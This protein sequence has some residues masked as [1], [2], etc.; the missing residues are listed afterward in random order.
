VKK[1][2]IIG[3]GILILL[4]GGA[5]YLL[6]QDKDDTTVT[7][8][9]ASEEK[10]VASTEASQAPVANTGVVITFT[11]NGF[12][13]SQYTVRAGAVVTVKNESDMNMQFSSDDHPTHRE[14]PELNMEVLS[15]GESGT[16]TANTTGTHGFHDHINDQ[17]T[18]ILEVQ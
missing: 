9:S 3:I 6:T 7:S 4:G 2:A 8:T 14:D 1:T 16:F 11:N 5:V 10:K 12:D 17:Y 18:G 15:P 13:K